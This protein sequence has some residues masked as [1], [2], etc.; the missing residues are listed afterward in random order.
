MNVQQIEQHRTLVT[1]IVDGYQG[2]SGASPPV[3]YPEH[4]W[5]LPNTDPR[6][7]G[8]S[9]SRLHTLDI[10]F[11]TAEDANSFVAILRKLL[12]PEQLDLPL[13]STG[14]ER[15]I[16]PVVKQLESVAIQDPAYRNEQTVNPGS[17]ISTSNPQK[18]ASGILGEFPKPAKPERKRRRLQRQKQELGWLQQHTGMIHIR[19]FHPHRS[20]KTRF[21]T[22]FMVGRTV[23][24]ILLPASLIT[25]LIPHNRPNPVTW[26]DHRKGKRIRTR[27]CRL[28]HMY[29]RPTHTKVRGDIPLLRQATRAHRLRM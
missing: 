25:G 13:L 15:I 14:Q 28:P 9:L 27:A 19:G 4:Y 26:V 11:W 18:N 5:H 3:Q 23:I 17:A 10:Y 21:P 2:G 8:K 1:V 22:L 24:S 20:H 29:H 16:D 12:R 7:E 6:P